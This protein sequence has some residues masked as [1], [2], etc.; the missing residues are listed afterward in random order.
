MNYPSLRS[1]A[2]NTVDGSLAKAAG[3]EDAML[4]KSNP[5]ATT[6]FEKRKVNLWFRRAMKNDG[7]D[8]TG[9]VI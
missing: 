8:F 4:N 3:H 9:D 5:A 1:A 2:M 6:V 7:E